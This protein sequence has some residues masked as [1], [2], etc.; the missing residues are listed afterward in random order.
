[1]KRIFI[2]LI[3]VVISLA[4]TCSAATDWEWVCSDSNRTY[5]IDRS[6]LKTV[7]ADDGSVKSKRCFVKVNYTDASARE[8]LRSANI[9][10]SSTSVYSIF[11][12]TFNFSDDSTFVNS[13]SLYNNQGAAIFK[14]PSFKKY[15][16]DDH[17]SPVFYFFIQEFAGGNSFDLFK[18]DHLGFSS[19]FSDSNQKKFY[20]FFDKLSV[21]KDG[22]CI[23]CNFFIFGDSPDKSSLNSVRFYYT[24]FDTTNDVFS[25]I[26]QSSYKIFNGR[27]VLNQ[28]E[29]FSHD[30]YPEA[31]AATIYNKVI[32]FCNDNPFW[33]NRHNGSGIMPKAFVGH[34][35]I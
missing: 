10:P 17:F 22:S 32:E 1:M 24:V 9:Y 21:Y 13:G 14:Y 5:S 35:I 27:Y 20:V 2:L 18:S 8:E 3:I 25:V 31:W 7:L 12:I 30:I 11:D 4:P 26:K 33:V 15:M 34:P 16:R 19:A 6:S 23:Y 29:L 28:D